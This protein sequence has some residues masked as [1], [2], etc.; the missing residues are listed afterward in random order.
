MTSTR[1]TPQWTP[2]LEEAFGASGAKGR[3]GELFVKEAVES[4]G[5][6]VIDNEASYEE[7]VAGQD[8]WIKKPTWHNHYSIDVKNNMNDFG[9][10]YVD[11][12][13]WM[14][15]EKK[16]HRFWHVNIE[17]GWMA[18]YGREDM[19]NYIITKN[20]TKGF[21]VGVKDKTAVNITRRHYAK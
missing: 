6:D 14:K 19:Q 3:E 11:P 21:W 15:P 2:T 1:L 18:W 9:A 10:F 4:W 17:T 12:V 16:N 5:W 7:Q 13:E 20:K 8:L